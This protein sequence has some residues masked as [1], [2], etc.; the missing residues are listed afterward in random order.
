MTSEPS[1]QD[2]P[3]EIHEKRLEIAINNAIREMGKAMQLVCD[4]P[5]VGL[6]A[7]G[8]MALTIRSWC[9]TIQM[10]RGDKAKVAAAREKNANELDEM[11]GN[12]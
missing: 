2:N 10:I 8:N 5:D 7:I 1:P 9:E 4:D 3:Q 12:A 6:P 11:T